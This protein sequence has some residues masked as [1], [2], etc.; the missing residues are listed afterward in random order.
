MRDAVGGQDFYYFLRELYTV[1]GLVNNRGH[2][3]ERYLY[4]AYGKASIVIVNIHDIDYNGV[5]NT[6]DRG[7]VMT[8]TA[9]CDDPITDLDA[10]GVINAA[11][12]GFITANYGPGL[13]ASKV[14]GVDNP[15]L[16]TGRDLDVYYNGPTDSGDDVDFAVQ[17]NRARY[18]DAENGRWM[19]RDPLDYVDGGDLYEYAQSLPPS[20]SDP[21][22]ER[23]FTYELNLGQ[24]PMGLSVYF[25]VE[26]TQD[27]CCLEVAAFGAVEWQPPGLHYVAKPLEWVNVHL[28]FGARG[29]IKGS[30]RA[31]LPGCVREVKVCGRFEVFGRADYRRKG[32]REDWGRGRFTRMRFGAGADGGGEICYN[33]CNGNVTASGQISWWAYAHFGWSWF[34]R[35]YEYGNSWTLA[36]TTLATLDAPLSDYCCRN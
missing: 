31:C 14:S 27:N 8:G 15:Y 4:D 18:Y 17:Y 7:F 28:E 36:Q 34:N 3:V 22:G 21:F 24:T 29:G 19:Q 26:G 1:D 32:A 5:V 9:A 13:V 2:E 12:K 33:L 16:F 35:S 11:D 20:R 6:G 30:V 23:T 10:N 25:R